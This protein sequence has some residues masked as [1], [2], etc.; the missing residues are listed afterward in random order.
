MNFFI[1]KKTDINEVT[2]WMKSKGC[3]S[4]R[5]APLDVVRRPFFAEG[6][7]EPKSKSHGYG[8]STRNACH[9]VGQTRGVGDLKSTNAGNPSGQYT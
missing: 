2:L 6:L 9:S 5:L 4:Q 1:I 3:K 7:H 8:E